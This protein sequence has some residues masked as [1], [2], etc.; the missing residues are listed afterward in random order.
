MSD[1]E[2]PDFEE[3]LS[4]YDIPASG[5]LSDET[6]LVSPFSAGIAVLFVVVALLSLI[7]RLLVS[8]DG[9]LIAGVIVVVLG[10][11]MIMSASKHRMRKK[12]KR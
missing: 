10:A 11:V 8:V 9:V 1:T 5:S 3:M 12:H 2:T 4:Q 7:N 6:R